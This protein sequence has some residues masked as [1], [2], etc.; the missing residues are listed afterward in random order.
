M[1]YSGDS[2]ELSVVAVP[3]SSMRTVRMKSG[4]LGSFVATGT[5]TDGRYGL[6]RWDMP[7]NS[8][9]A[10][11]HFH[12]SFSEAFYVLEGAPSFYNG[13]A[14]T[15]G[16]PGDYLYVPEG[17]IHGFRN[18]TNASA[19]ML[20]LFAPGIAREAYFEELAEI[21]ASGRQMTKTDWADLYARHDQ[22]MVEMAT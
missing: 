17:G 4:T 16:A 9:G 7:A 12:R 1:S 13:D 2:G 8:G 22:V 20:N 6:Y 18:D 11:G 21:G 10:G 14:G 15:P 3:S 5:L 19:S